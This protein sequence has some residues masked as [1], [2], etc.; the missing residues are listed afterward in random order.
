M[1]MRVKAGHQ[2]GMV[3]KLEPMRVSCQSLQRQVWES[4]RVWGRTDRAVQ[5]HVAQ[6]AGEEEAELHGGLVSVPDAHAIVGDHGAHGVVACIVPLLLAQLQHLLQ[7]L[8]QV[9]VRL[10]QQRQLP[11]LAHCSAARN[12]STAEKD[13]CHVQLLPLHTSCPTIGRRQGL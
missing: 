9:P 12:I 13:S 6:A 7:L 3:G 8:A 1:A 5:V 4:R 11:E 2:G 10:S